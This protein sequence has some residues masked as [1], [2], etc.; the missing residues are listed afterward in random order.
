LK[1]ES[2]LIEYLVANDQS[3]D[4]DHGEKP[5]FEVRQKP[6]FHHFSS[7]FLSGDQNSREALARFS[8]ALAET[9]TYSSQVRE[10]TKPALIHN[11]LVDRSRQTNVCY[12]ARS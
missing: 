1:P 9:L 7:S 3:A 8:P 11:Q 5:R 4:L 10:R 6:L 2:S 12:Q